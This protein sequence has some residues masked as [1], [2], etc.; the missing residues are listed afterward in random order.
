M[1]AITH[2]RKDLMIEG[3]FLPVDLADLQQFRR[4]LI[5]F[6][7]A[8]GSAEVS[9]ARAVQVANGITGWITSKADPDY[10]EDEQPKAPTRSQYRRILAELAES[11]GGGGGGGERGFAHLHAVADLAANSVGVAALASGRPWLG[12]LAFAHNLRTESYVEL[13]GGRSWDG[14]CELL[15]ARRFE[16]GGRV[17][18][19]SGVV[20]GVVAGGRYL[21]VGAAAGGSARAAA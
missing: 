4:R 3:D 9:P 10:L 18:R 8:G 7:R 21:G 14:S 17:D 6:L 20:L 19:A 5:K 1:T 15:L 16:G 12:A 11:G 13:A 2:H